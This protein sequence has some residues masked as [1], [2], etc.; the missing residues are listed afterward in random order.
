MS[1][2]E[3]PDILAEYA[4]MKDY[5][6]P[7]QVNMDFHWSMEGTAPGPFTHGD[8]VEISCLAVD[9]Q[10][11]ITDLYFP[12]KPKAIVNLWQTNEQTAGFLSWIVRTWH[13]QVCLET[14]TNRGRS[15]KAICDALDINASGHLTTV[16]MAD[17][18]VGSRHER[19]TFVQGRSPDVLGNAV[20]L[21]GVDFAYLDG[22]HNKEAVMSEVEYIKKNVSDRGCY[23]LFDDASNAGWPGV[24]EACAELGAF[25]LPTPHGLGILKL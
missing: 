24:G 25:I 2:Q 15:T 13:P 9:P 22:D 11:A 12:D 17:H 6:G 10:G 8:E 14:G 18:G 19:C 7:A 16:D 20:K 1:T 4:S 23:V 3:H 21:H 5:D